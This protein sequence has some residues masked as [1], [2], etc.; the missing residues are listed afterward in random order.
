MA[1]GLFTNHP[2]QEELKMMVTANMMP[3]RSDVYELWIANAIS[4]D[5]D[6]SLCHLQRRL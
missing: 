4:V 2:E 5:V 6:V 1:V 3:M